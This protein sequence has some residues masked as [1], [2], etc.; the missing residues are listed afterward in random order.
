MKGELSFTQYK[1]HSIQGCCAY[2]AESYKE[3]KNTN[4]N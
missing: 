2:K 4:K 3:K 1:I